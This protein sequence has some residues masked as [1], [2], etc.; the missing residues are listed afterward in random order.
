VL[1]APRSM[2]PAAAADV[3]RRKIPDPTKPMTVA[4][5]SV[6]S[7]L[8]LRDAEAGL[9]WL[10]S[11]YRGHLRVTED[12]DLVHVFPNAFT[13]P[14]ETREATWRVLSAIGGALFA[15]GRFV[16]RAWLL[17]AMIA[18]ALIFVAIIIGLTFARQSDRDDGVGVG[19]GLL[20]GLF[21]AIADAL[22]WTFHPFSPL[23]YGYGYGASYNDGYAGVRRESARDPN[24]VPFYEKV[25]RFVFGPSVPPADPHAMRTR[26][27]E[28]IRA[29]KG[30]I[31]L[32]DVMRVTGLPRDEADPLMA[33]LMLDHEGTVEVAEQGGIIY[34]FEGLRRTAEATTPMPGP[35][36][37]ARRAAWET[38]AKLAPLTGNNG[39]ANFAI[40]A[41]NGFNLLASG[42]VLAH[43]LTI[44]NLFTLLTTHPPRGAPPLVLP[45]DGVPL[46]LGLVPFLFSIA[47]FVLPTLRAVART[48]QEK[49]VAQENAR[50]A[51]LREVLTRAPKKEPVPD[52]VLR[53]AYR[54]AT[55]VD[56]TSKEIT[57]RVVDLGGDV[58]VGP[59]GEVRYRFADLEAEAEALEEERA[60]APA[61]EAKLGRVVFASD[62]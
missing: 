24:E 13:K 38:P 27:L 51:I 56:P 50:L 9:H 34:R 37:S 29:Q 49:K 43:G 58:D 2:E 57:A 59:A 1:E 45:Y 44:S 33:R 31:G 40:A 32:A 25:N 52:E 3:L 39:G 11:E 48:R 47:L 17:I 4:D 30:R 12:G 14:W 6:A 60:H 16:V 21:R 55:G 54:V 26:I 28:E 36:R 7:G 46:A 41:L 10:T 53:V 8:P 15:A 22:F 62:E 61:R 18:Y 5:A 35:D 20:G 23:Y 19:A 42:W